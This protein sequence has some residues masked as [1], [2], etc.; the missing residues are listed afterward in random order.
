MFLDRT[1]DRWIFFT[2]SGYYYARPGAEKFVGWLIDRGSEQGP[3][4]FS[5]GQFAGRFCRMSVVQHMLDTLD[6]AEALKQA[7]APVVATPL[8][9]D[10]P[11][12]VTIVSPQDGSRVAGA[13][14]PIDYVLRSPS[15][16]AVREVRVFIDGRPAPVNVPVP[17]VARAHPYDEA[18]PGHVTIPAPP[19]QTFTLSIV[20]A[21][22]PRRYGPAAAVKLVSADQPYPSAPARRRLFALIIG[23]QSY[24]RLP[25]ELRKLQ[26]A[27][28]DAKSVA[29]LISGSQQRRIYDDVEVRLLVDGGSAPP[30]REAILDGLNWLRHSAVLPDDVALFFI[31]SHGQSG[32][33]DNNYQNDLLL[34]PTD[35]DLMD[36]AATTISGRTLV[37]D[38]KDIPGNVILMID[39]CYAG[40]VTLPDTNRF[41][42]DA[43]SPWGG[44]FVFTSS[45]TNELSHEDP[46]H[47]HGR[48]TQALIEALHG[49]SGMKAVDGVILTDYLASYLA[50]RVP[51]LGSSDSPQKPLFASP[52][53]APDIRAFAVV[54]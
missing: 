7:G 8:A 1:A 39:A 52:A 48:F 49:Q 54:N 4:F 18:V 40:G 36:L 10:V 31:S 14:I 21:T 22:D 47:G 50:H 5:V 13:T 11:P 9:M 46:Q 35:A 27:A 3:D 25:Q 38:L 2:P 41:V 37:D 15:G 34:L 53:H 43:S 19:D 30:T 42:A 45:S 51:E 6:E 24:A 29:E 20:A 23:V 16:R 17:P 12:I 28:Q 32:Q 33:T 44:M 26:Y